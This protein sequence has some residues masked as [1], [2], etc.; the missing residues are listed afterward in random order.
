[1]DMEV[2]MG[3]SNRLYTL[4]LV[5]LALLAAL[6]GLVG[7]IAAEQLPNWLDPFI[8]WAW[9]A[10][11]AITVATIILVVLQARMEGGE[12]SNS[13]QS[14]TPLVE[15]SVSKR[16]LPYHNLPQPDYSVFVGREKELARISRILRPYPHSQ[17]HLV[18][19]DGV[20]GVG[21]SALALEMAH[22]YR[23]EYSRIPEE[24]RFDAIIW[25]S[26]KA[27]VLTADGIVS[28]PQITRTL[29]NIYTT[30]SITL[31][32]EDITR[33]PLE[34]RDKLVSKALTRQ[35]TL[36]IVDN[37]ETVDDEGVIVFLRELPAPTK[38]IVTTRHRI[39]VAYPIRLVGISWNE[40]QS[41]IIRTCKEKE[42]TLTKQQIRRLYDRTGGIPV[43]LVWSIA[44]MG[45]GHHCD[46][47]LNQL[48]NPQ[49][50]IARF[51]F[52]STV[53]QIKGKPAHKLLQALSV[54]ATDASRDTLGAVAGF[55]VDISSRN[56]GLVELEK[57]S[58]ANK[59]NERFSL[60]PLTKV[61]AASLLPNDEEFR[62]RQ[63]IVYLDFCQKYGGPT[64]NWENY[65]QID[66]ER[67]NVIDLMEW[68]LGRQRWQTLVDLQDTLWEY[69]ELRSYWSE[70]EKWCQHALEAGAHLSIATP[71]DIEN[72]RKM[73]TFHLALCWV[74]INQ[75]QFDAARTEANDALAILEP[76]EARHGIAVAHRHLGLIEKLRGEFYQDRGEVGQAEQHFALA[77]KHY[78]IALGIWRKL[79]DQREISSVLAN[80]GHQLITQDKYSEARDFL[81]QALKLQRKVNDT[82][83]LSTNLRAL[84][85]IAGKEGKQDIAEQYYS[86]ALTIATKVDDKLSAGRAAFELA[87]LYRQRGNAQSVIQF[88]RKSVEFLAV[89]NKTTYIE[90][91]IKRAMELLQ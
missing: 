91:D 33:A 27:S 78:E 80:I 23:R 81:E 12:K 18:T 64:I 52:H 7:E 57:L 6:G 11:I 5:L 46:E 71:L 59:Q 79:D 74:R 15:L 35:R 85:F 38:A 43:A 44:R 37:L 61:Y 40:A 86:E 63:E 24:D 66:T 25:T 90:R 58:L 45:Y 87:E 17:E 39:D 34:Q 20:G 4:L 19:I 14:S 70:Q 30:V 13:P 72:Q 10:F 60:L 51:C 32:Q 65:A 73:G 31:D 76:L 48:G 8:P 22:R 89:L 75:E 26:A 67:Q 16:P 47:V 49:A 1:M 9:P 54:F 29:D 55:D 53:E 21:K 42:V 84:G 62:L 28:R 69:W 88:A 82:S 3:K 2:S 36:L 77:R 56:E 83:R 68:C 41:L 50:D